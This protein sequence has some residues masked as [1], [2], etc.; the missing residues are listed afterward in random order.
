MTGS[1]TTARHE[2]YFNLHKQCLSMRPMGGK[3]SHISVVILDDVTFA[4]QPAGNARVR[5]EGKKN[6]HAFVRGVPC[7]VILQGMPNDSDYT[8]TNMDRQGYRRISYNPYKSDYFYFVDNGERI[9]KASQVVMIGK[10]IYL[11]GSKR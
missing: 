9:D 7:F 11:S 3:V 4:V 1:P 6:V 8:F 5:A 2:V 10:Y